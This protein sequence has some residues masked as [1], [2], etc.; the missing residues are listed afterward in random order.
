MRI[1]EL[2]TQLKLILFDLTKP[3]SRIAQSAW[4]IASFSIVNR[5]APAYA[6]ASAG[7]PAYAKAS[8]RQAWRQG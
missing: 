4:S 6:K 2:S 1:A 5:E 3:T 7:K 8:S